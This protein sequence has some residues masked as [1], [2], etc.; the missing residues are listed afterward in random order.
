MNEEER[1]RERERERDERR[2]DRVSETEKIGESNI[3]DK[4]YIQEI[5]V[6]FF[7][8]FPWLGWFLPQ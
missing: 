4:N 3:Q 2:R 5:K 6:L 1:E 8:S 7:I